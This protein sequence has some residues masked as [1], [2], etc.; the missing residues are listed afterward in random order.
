MQGSYTNK[1]A[2]TNTRV[3]TFGRKGGLFSGADFLDKRDSN[4]EK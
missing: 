4:V 1:L 3:L 2:I